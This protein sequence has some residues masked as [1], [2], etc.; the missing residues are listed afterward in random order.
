MTEPLLFADLRID[1][2]LEDEIPLRPALGTLIGLTPEVLAENRAWLQP[3]ALDAQDV[4]RVAIQS[5]LV[6]TPHHTILIDSCVGNDKAIERMPVWHKKTDT[7]FMDGLAALGVGLE[8]IDYVLCTHLHVD[9]VGW[10]TRLENGRWVPTF[11]NARYVFGR[12]EYD[13]WHAEN[14][15]AEN[16]VFTDSVLP[17]VQADRADLVADEFGIGD[18]LRL[19]PTPGHTP[20]HVS[21]AL[22]AERDEAVVSGD[23]LHSP[24]QTRY[25]DLS[26]VFDSDPAK[27]VKSRRGFLERYAETPT[28]CCMTHFPSPSIG[29]LKRW[30][31]G[32]RCEYL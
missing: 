17:V 16:T 15:K 14:A 18:H 23:V 13:H 30:G 6:R 20:G 3:D 31:E 8:A 26:I 29:R 10:N 1:R 11:P 5:F 24:L 2:V 9:H 28:I 22:G 19:L 21:V 32:F 12:T 27:A 25:P 7:N 4:L